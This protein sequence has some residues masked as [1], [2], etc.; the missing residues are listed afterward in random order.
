MLAKK[1]SMMNDIRAQIDTLAENTFD[2]Y[3][4]AFKKLFVIQDIEAWSPAIRSATAI[5]SRL[6]R[7]FSDPPIVIAALGLT[8]ETLKMDL[9]TFG[10][11]FECMCIRDLKAYSQVF[12]SSI[13]Y[14]HDRYNLEADAVMHLTDGR[15]AL[16]EFK[17]GGKEIDEG[18]A[19]LLEIQSLVKEFNKAK[20]QM[21]LREP[22]LLMV[23]TGGPIAYSRPDGVKVL[24]LACLRD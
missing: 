20:K 16:I 22:D 24:P 21:K 12:G 23:I 2:S 8:P 4:N 3:V 18:A 19:H 17:L 10:F 13:S 15:Y 5:C 9:K 1:S 7:G 14:Y 11:I 6:K